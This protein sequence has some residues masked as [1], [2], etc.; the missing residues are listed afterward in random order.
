MAT[1]ALMT[2][3]ASAAGGVGEWHAREKDEKYGT[4]TYAARFLSL[5]DDVINKGQENGYLSKTNTASGGFGVPYHS[6]EELIC[7]APDYGH[8]T[9][10]EAMSYIVWIAAMND[11]ITKEQAGKIDGVSATS[12]LAKAWKTLEMMIPDASQQKGF[13]E[14]SS[15]KGLSA[16]TSKEWPEGPENYPSEGNQQNVGINPIQQDFSTLSIWSIMQ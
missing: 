2:T 11:H 7:E 4:D 6:I 14:K 1:S 8:E 9:T 3:V 5:Y 13:F 12:D 10:S 16:Q 15:S